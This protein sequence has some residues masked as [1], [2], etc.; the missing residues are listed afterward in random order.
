MIHG[1]VIPCDKL[2]FSQPTEAGMRLAAAYS[3]TDNFLVYGVS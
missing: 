2:A 3:N 1:Y